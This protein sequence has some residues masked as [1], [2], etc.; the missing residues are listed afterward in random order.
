M[1]RLFSRLP[2][3]EKPGRYPA[4]PSDFEAL[5]RTIRVG[6]VLLVEGRARVSSV[7]K[8]VMQSTWSHAALCVADMNAPRAFASLVLYRCRQARA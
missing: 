4:V 6:D 2:E 5:C 3:H 8:Y 1:G 7:I